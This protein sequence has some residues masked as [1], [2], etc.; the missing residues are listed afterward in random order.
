MV[1]AGK[2]GWR[3]LGW[4]GL[5]S[6]SVWGAFGVSLLSRP[7]LGSKVLTDGLADSRVQNW[8][9]FLIVFG[10]SFANASYLFNSRRRYDMRFR[11]VGPSRLPTPVDSSAR[12]DEVVFQDQL[13][14][15]NARSVPVPN[16]R[17][18]EMEDED[19]AQ[20]TA[21]KVF[22]LVWYVIP[23]PIPLTRVTS[24]GIDSSWLSC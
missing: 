2:Q 17:D 10:I 23:H 14:T 20:W 11:K 6:T 4:L 18:L 12:A 5:G 24:I 9:F 1:E 16:S 21:K 8:L 15:P 13:N 3:I 22:F 7:T 19:L